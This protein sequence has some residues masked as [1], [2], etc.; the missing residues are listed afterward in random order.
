MPPEAGIS[1]PQMN[2]GDTIDFLPC[3]T[4]GYLC[5][6]IIQIYPVSLLRVTYFWVRSF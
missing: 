6:F 5:P 2:T 1:E 3:Q 4:R